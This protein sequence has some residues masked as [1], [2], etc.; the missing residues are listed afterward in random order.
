MQKGLVMG[1]MGEGLARISTLTLAGELGW[2]GQSWAALK[3]PLL[4]PCLP[5]LPQLCPAPCLLLCQ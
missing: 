3:S 1:T 4:L 2:G 5:L